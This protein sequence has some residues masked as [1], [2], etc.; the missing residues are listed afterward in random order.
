MVITDTVESLTKNSINYDRLQELKAF[1]ES[2]A[3]VKGLVDAS[4]TKIPIIF[5]RPPED[6]ARDFPSFGDPTSYRFTIPVI[7]LGDTIGRHAK[8][9]RR[10]AEIGFFQVVSHGIDE[11]VLEEMLAAVRRF[12]E[13]PRE[14][15]AE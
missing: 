14:V 1:D 7:N 15:K 6:I 5:V 2:K 8:S 3:G 10:A 4:I 13:L 11:S 12:H 9:V